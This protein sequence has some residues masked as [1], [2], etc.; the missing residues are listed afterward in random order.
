[1]PDDFGRLSPINQPF[2]QG[3]VGEDRFRGNTPRNR[4]QKKSAKGEKESDEG[5]AAEQAET[6]VSSNRID[7]LV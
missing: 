6:P 4:R 2:L 5:A 7:L 1:M 3:V